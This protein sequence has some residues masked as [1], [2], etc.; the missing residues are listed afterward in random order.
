MAHLTK[1]ELVWRFPRHVSAQHISAN[2]PSICSVL[3]HAGQRMEAV[4]KW[5]EAPTHDSEW[6]VTVFYERL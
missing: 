6:K 3:H 4:T 2:T 1:L 5:S